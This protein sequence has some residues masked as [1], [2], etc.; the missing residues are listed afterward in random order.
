MTLG[1]GVIG[2]GVLGRRHAE[3]VARLGPR[4]RLVAVADVNAEAARAVA[5]ELGCDWTADPRELVARPDV[6]A[7]VIA[8]GSDTHAALT[9]AA[10]AEGKDSLCEK[11]LALTVADAQAAVDAADRAGVR[12]QV[13]FMRRYDPAY[14][15]A[16]EAI[17][18][19]EI[20]R[21]VLFA[22]ISRDAQPPPRA[23]FISPGAG[24]LFIDSGIHDFDLARWLMRDEVATVSA[25]GALVACHDQADVQPIDLGL[26]TL[27]FRGGAAGTVQ[28]Y[29]RAV[30]GYDIRTE[31]VGTEGT[32]RVGDDRWRSLQVMRAEGIT[33]TMPHH[34]LE[35]FGE[36]YALELADWVE[37]MAGDRPAAVTGEDGV[38][39]VALAVAADEARASGRPVEMR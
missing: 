30:Y 18:R 36:A 7:V 25:T 23:Y 4:A 33:H 24:G 10:A 34:W 12:L 19:G 14:R 1:V 28:V 13:G 9:V 27:S 26:A 35:R 6:R 29:R 5:R 20:G 15:A 31:V 37:R 17:E 22:A 2:V 39:S 32:V 16:Y 3:N 38:R 8:T 11:P 21:P